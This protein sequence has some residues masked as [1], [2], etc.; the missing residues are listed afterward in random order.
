MRLARRN[1]PDV[2]KLSG[3]TALA[4]AEMTAETDSPPGADGT[5]AAPTAISSHSLS[6]TYVG[7]YRRTR[8]F[9]YVRSRQLEGC[10][11]RLVVLNVLV[12]GLKSGMLS[13]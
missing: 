2:R 8:C 13:W 3:A 10:L 7:L 5:H 11:N 4:I 9:D 6:P 12:T 1:P